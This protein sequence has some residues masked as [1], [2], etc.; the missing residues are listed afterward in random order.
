MAKRKRS[1]SSVLFGALW[2][3]ALTVSCFIAMTPSTVTT[4]FVWSLVAF[5]CVLIL[6]PLSNNILGRQMLLSICTLVMFR[7]LYWRVTDTMPSYE[8]PL[9]FLAAV[10]LLV[11]EF[12]MIV[13]FVLGSMMIADARRRVAPP[14]IKAEEIPSVD[15][16]IP[17]YNEPEEMLSVTIAAAI[18]V[19]YPAGKL[20][21]VL[22]DDGGTDERINSSDPEIASAALL[23]RQRLKEL[24]AK[25]G[26]I[27]IT[28]PANVMAKAGNLNH[29]MQHLDGELVAIFDA[30]HAPTPDFLARTVG[31]FVRNPNLFLVQTPHNFL[32]PDPIAKNLKIDH[33]SPPEQDMFYNVLLDGLD[34]FRG[35][36]FC[37]SAA[38]LR[39]KALDEVGG[40]SGRTITEDAE[41]AL[42]LHR[43]GWDSLYVNRAMIAGVQPETFASLVQQR[44]RWAT[45]MI[46]LFRT[47]NPLFAR[48]LT[49]SQRLCYLN[50]M[51]FWFFPVARL[52]MLIAPMCYIF[53]GLELF[54]ATY[55]EAL[56]YMFGYMATSYVTQNALYARTRW[57]FQSELYE[58][59]LSPYLVGT[60]FKTLFSPTRASFKVTAKDEV[61]DKTRLSPIALP[62]IVLCLLTILAVIVSIFRWFYEPG[63][64][65]ALSI[66]G[67]WA[68]FNMIITCASVRAVV[69]QKQV[70][71]N[72]RIRLRHPVT[73]RAVG[74]WQPGAT[75]VPEFD[76]TLV[77]ASTSGAAVVFPIGDAKGL[78]QKN[79]KI[80]LS[81]PQ[82]GEPGELVGRV[83][84]RD[85][86]QESTRIRMEFDA[87][88]SASGLRIRSALLHNDSQIW[89]DTIRA[90]TQAR[91]LTVALFW[92]LR[93]ALVGP[94]MVVLALFRG[95]TRSSDR[96]DRTNR[97]ALTNSPFKQTAQGQPAPAMAQPMGPVPGR[98]GAP[99]TGGGVGAGPVYGTSGSFGPSYAGRTQAAAPYG[100]LPQS[101]GAVAR[102]DAPAPVSYPQQPGGYV[103]TPPNGPVPGGYGQTMAPTH[104]ERPAG[105]TYPQPQQQP[106]QEPRVKMKRPDPKPI[107]P[108]PTGLAA[109]ALAV[110]LAALGT[111]DVAQAQQVPVP[112]VEIDP[113]AR[114][115]ERTRVVEPEESARKKTDFPRVSPVPR[116]RPGTPVA[117]VREVRVQAQPRQS[118]AVVIP[119]TTTERTEPRA[120]PVALATT[121]VRPAKDSSAVVVP[122]VT[123]ESSQPVRVEREVIVADADTAVV[124]EQADTSGTFRALPDSLLSPVFAP[125]RMVQGDPAFD[126]DRIRLAGER[127][128]R[129]AL[130]ILPPNARPDT[131]VLHMQSSAYV[132]SEYSLM[133]VTVNGV[134]LGREELEQIAGSQDVTFAISPDVPLYVRNVV[135]I[136]VAQTHRVACGYDASFELWTDVYLRRSGAE[137]PGDAYESSDLATTMARMASDAGAGQAIRVKATGSAAEQAGHA[138]RMDVLA[139]VGGL[140]GGPLRYTGSP[141]EMEIELT[142]SVTGVAP[143][144]NGLAIGMTQG[145]RADL[146]QLRRAMT[147][148]ANMDVATR[149]SMVEPN[150]AVRLSELGLDS[151]LV[152]DYFWSRSMSFEL[153]SGYHSVTGDR[154]ELLLSYA[155]VAGLTDGSAMRIY[156]NDTQV[157]IIPI[158]SRTPASELNLPV[159]F[160]AGLLDGGL[161][162]LR[163]DVT[164]E[165]PE[166]AVDCT[167]ASTP[168]LEIDTASTLEI[169]RSPAFRRETIGSILTGLSPQGLD[170][171]R[172]SLQGTRRERQTELANVYSM[173]AALP[174]GR[175]Q[176]GDRLVVLSETALEGLNL[177]EYVSSRPEMLQLMRSAPDEAPLRPNRELVPEPRPEP[178]EPLVDAQPETED[179]IIERERDPFEPSG[180]GLLP[181]IQP[182]E[183]A[184]NASVLSIDD[185]WNGSVTVQDWVFPHPPSQL[186]RWLSHNL[187]VEGAASDG[188]MIFQLD[189]NNRRAYFIVGEDAS[190]PDA[191]EALHIAMQTPA[192]MNGHFAVYRPDVGWQV[193]ADKS[194]LPELIEPLR[195]DNAGRVVGTYAGAR[196]REFALLL[197]IA[198]AITAVCA[199]LSLLAS[200]RNKR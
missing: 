82:L 67:G 74:I 96:E 173:A 4:Q 25:L 101:S 70:R 8:D 32:N 183:G 115:A 39:R 23:R 60:V 189:D 155:H 195:L 35:A 68:I 15:I 142:P 153:P 88:Q 138:A 105:P 180:D 72:P 55:T 54:V 125:L 168:V 94:A 17:S 9:S 34:R 81:A 93:L 108:T 129:T 102:G 121:P 103:F 160:D 59:A 11:T 185:L 97:D 85:F 19:Q 141:S 83:V 110:G 26:A 175:G 43:R 191:L 7:Y 107:R 199:T 136:E 56:V 38:V 196:P 49:F 149:A 177:G 84:G 29:A 163:I 61:N 172:N 69:D 106:Q 90:V 77:N 128:S 154:A 114:P 87:E 184:N 47:R 179:S 188:A 178:A 1:F 150:T 30:D 161:N 36:L 124:V 200:R 58:I 192:R 112:F 135:K 80:S 159:R 118:E 89:E 165:A 78:P 166:T 27:Y 111:P 182:R 18:R 45:G 65:E 198:A 169:P 143:T 156:V 57:P 122:R 152:R 181:R 22:C 44:G 52:V 130:W 75:A 126:Q 170:I 53:F 140:I 100:P 190:L 6:R 132:L 31:Y 162:V 133:R 148:P 120:R 104:P 28:R 71:L 187:R 194:R 144:N 145:G 86:N 2:I 127:A 119:R 62:L 113:N 193:W 197:I 16:L 116:L 63:N 48:G 51:I 139:Q 176:D 64:H 92:I 157:R 14:E 174:W 42:E 167:V 13:V 66:V 5:I 171:D 33:N 186:K 164:R 46:Q 79:E 134:E 76:G 91:G 73:A 10:I 20:R 12:Y 146:S 123:V 21:V 151:A 50:S 109:I 158:D 137:L 24:C 147:E 3:L 40:I 41:T 131:M 98:S 37:G 99:G 117:P 95:V